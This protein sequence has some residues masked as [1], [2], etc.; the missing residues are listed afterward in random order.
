MGAEERADAA[1]ESRAYLLATLRA[2]AWAAGTVVFLLIGYGQAWA[3]VPML[4]G[5][6]LGIVLLL[7]L[8]IFVRRVFQPGL[9]EKNAAA[10][11]RRGAFLLF[12]LVKYPM[13]GT[14]IWWIVRHWEPRAVMAFAGGFILLQ[15]VIGLRAVGRALTQG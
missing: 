11:R 9:W 5:L 2:T 10:G 14:L 13:V 8:D 1:P 12:A 4:D 7:G 3:V 15:A 6:I